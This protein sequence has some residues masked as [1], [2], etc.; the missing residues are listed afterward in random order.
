VHPEGLKGEKTE[1][2]VAGDRERIGV[3]NKE[4]N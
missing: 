1:N 3:G 4:K 2:G